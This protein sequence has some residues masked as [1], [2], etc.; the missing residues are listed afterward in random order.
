MDKLFQ[1]KWAI[2]ILALVFAICLYLFVGIEG[3]D[4]AKSD[5]SVIPSQSD[6]SEVQVLDDIPLEVKIDDDYVVSGVPETVSVS[7]EGKRRI[8][9]PVVQQRN[10]KM[11]VDL[12]GLSEGEHT[13][14][15]EY[16]NIP[17]ELEVFTEPKSIDV[18]I[19]KRAAEEFP[20]DVDVV[21]QDKLPVGYELGEPEVNPGTVSIVSSEEVIN[22]IAMVKVFIDATDLTESIKNREVPV[23]VYDGQGNGLNVR[24]EPENVSVS[25]SVDRPSK[26][27]P[28]NVETKG[29]LP[30]G[31]GMK[32]IETDKEI[33]VFGKR[34]VLD[35]VDNIST[36]PVDLSEIEKSGD[37]DVKLDLPEGIVAEEETVPVKIELEEEKVF[38][39]I[40]LEF[41][42]AEEEDVTFEKPESGKVNI[43]AKGSDEVMHKLEKEDV[44]V[45]LK[46]EDRGEGKHRVDVVTEGP[47]GITFKADPDK[48]TV[49][50]E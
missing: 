23:T 8:L 29:D 40:E 35:K 7:L 22:Q 20:V 6:S 41:E 34:E 45:Y 24:I 13:V 28:L 43:T 47:E 32:K 27:V 1:N 30:E 19:E 21:N 36:E 16:D 18:T 42:G 37:Y 11:Y 4:S 38:K 2:R 31:T 10:F 33:E 15:V 5:S 14:D 49:Q 3:G 26:K 48:A 25:M 17:D 50:I 46:L 44:K 12:Q 9:T 39:D